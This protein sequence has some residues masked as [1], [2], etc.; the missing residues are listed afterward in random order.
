M[1]ELMQVVRVHTDD[2]SHIEPPA[3]DDWSDDL[4]MAWHASVVAHDG[5]IA[6]RIGRGDGGYAISVSKHGGGYLGPFD[7]HTAWLYLIGIKLGAEAA[8]K[9]GA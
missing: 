2:G 8:R 9:A 6:V 1:L 5:Q 3:K 7:F 4:K